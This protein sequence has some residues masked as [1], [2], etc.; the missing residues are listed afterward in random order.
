MTF[1][2]QGSFT[3]TY[4]TEGNHPAFNVEPA[5][6][7]DVIQKQEITAIEGNL[8]AVVKFSEQLK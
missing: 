6:V 8:I 4:E 1:P 3:I 5:Q 7:G 2:L